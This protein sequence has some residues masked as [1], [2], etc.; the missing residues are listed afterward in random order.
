MVGGLGQHRDDAIEGWGVI[1]GDGLEQGD[2]GL[3]Q[4]HERLGVRHGLDR[5]RLFGV[6]S[7]RVYGRGRTAML[8]H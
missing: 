5:W 2:V 7:S 3:V 8:D 1:P 4:F 6:H